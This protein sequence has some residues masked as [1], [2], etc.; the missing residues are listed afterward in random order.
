M[1]FHFPRSGY[2]S[3]LEGYLVPAAKSFLNT[4][5]QLWDLPQPKTFT[6]RSRLL[7][8]SVS[9]LHGLH[10]HLTSFQ[11]MSSKP[12]PVCGNTLCWRITGSKLFGK[13]LLNEASS[14]SEGTSKN[15]RCSPF[16]SLL[17]ATRRTL[18][19]RQ[20]PQPSKTPMTAPAMHQESAGPTAMARP[21]TCKK[22]SQANSNLRSLNSWIWTTPLNKH[23]C[24]CE[25]NE[26]SHSKYGTQWYNMKVDSTKSPSTT[27]LVHVVNLCWRLDF[28]H[29]VHETP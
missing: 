29:G 24:Q 7:L 27:W 21:R 18:I 25:S 22:K 14:N 15:S 4:G 1:I 12:N 23:R 5:T 10:V 9:K 13:I 11:D 16:I 26:S 20:L 17:L 8:I 3:S 6:R 28:H 19:A 2:V